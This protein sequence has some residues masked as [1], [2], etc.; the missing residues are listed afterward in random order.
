M[1]ILMF[2][3]EK[4]AHETEIGNT[5]K[6]IQK[7]LSS[8]DIDIVLLHDVSIAIVSSLYL[9]LGKSGEVLYNK[10]FIDKD[11]RVRH[12]AVGDFFIC[13]FDKETCS[14][15]SLAPKIMEQLKKDCQDPDVTHILL[16][17]I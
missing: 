1:K 16:D 7:I 15:T 5:T 9:T 8:N 6:D 4:P 17:N 11:H 13:G 12:T 10:T 2:A 3:Y 14:L